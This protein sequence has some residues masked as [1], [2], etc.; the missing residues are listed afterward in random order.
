MLF[1]FIN[2][3]EVT[4]LTEANTPAAGD[5]TKFFYENVSKTQGLFIKTEIVLD[6]GMW[7]NTLGADRTACHLMRFNLKDKCFNGWP[8]NLET[9]NGVIVAG[10]E[11]LH[12]AMREAGYELYDVTYSYAFDL[13]RLQCHYFRKIDELVEEQVT[14]VAAVYRGDLNALLQPFG[15]QW[16]M[17]NID[18][19]TNRL[20]YAAVIDTDGTQAQSYRV[21]YQ[22]GKLPICAASRMELKE[23]LDEL[24]GGVPCWGDRRNHF[25]LQQGASWMQGKK[26]TKSFNLVMNDGNGVEVIYT[27]N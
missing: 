3:A 7:A 21:N 14:L 26:L 11:A 6:P 23:P 24:F 4:G 5:Q 12:D 9:S 19:E 1:N 25:V 2:V 20:G 15:E 18:P 10:N 22:Q 17:Y 16:V 27:G 13:A 8:S